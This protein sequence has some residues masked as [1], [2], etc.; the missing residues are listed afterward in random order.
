MGPTFSG[1]LIMEFEA[2]PIFP[3]GA[4]CEQAETYE[5]Q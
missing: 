3:E 4:I 1:L 5:S 2:L